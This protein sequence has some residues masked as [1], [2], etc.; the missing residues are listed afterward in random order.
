MVFQITVL[1]GG[2]NMVSIS[3]ASLDLGDTVKET[4][5]LKKKK[6][7]KSYELVFQKQWTFPLFYLKNEMRIKVK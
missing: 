5:L 3:C 2:P 7:G 1:F 4:D 6:K